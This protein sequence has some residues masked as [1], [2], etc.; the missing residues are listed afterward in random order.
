MYRYRQLEY[1]EPL[2]KISV[3]AR[4]QLHFAESET[5]LNPD[6]EQTP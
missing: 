1:I 3:L 2:L 5:Q 4:D 6:P